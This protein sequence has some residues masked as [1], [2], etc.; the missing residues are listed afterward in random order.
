MEYIISAEGLTK[1]FETDLARR[2]GIQQVLD[3]FSSENTLAP[4][5]IDLGEWSGMKQVEESL[6]NIGE[7]IEKWKE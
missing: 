6:D 2:S 4:I 5:E 7:S 1:T 3:N